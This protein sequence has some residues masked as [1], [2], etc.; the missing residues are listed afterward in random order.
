MQEK[1]D[2]T[3]ADQVRREA[4]QAVSHP[5]LRILMAGVLIVYGVSGWGVWTVFVA[6]GL[7]AIIAGVVCATVILVV[8]VTLALVFAYRAIRKSRPADQDNDTEE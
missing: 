8:M 3:V 7:P 4:R 5:L 1:P 6:P 2:P